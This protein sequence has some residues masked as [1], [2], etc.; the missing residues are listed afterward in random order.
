MQKELTQQQIS[1]MSE[2]VAKY[3]GV[4]VTQAY[5]KTKDQCGLH[6]TFPKEVKLPDSLI[7]RSCSI[8]EIRYHSSW[9]W[10]HEV[11]EKIKLENICTKEFSTHLDEIVQ[12][13]IN[14]TK[15]EAF[16]ALFNVVEF[17]NE[18]KK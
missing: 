15:I 7:Y 16:T 10:I 14:G 9:D 1:S 11:W 13:I 8:I 5:S 17:I 2:V 12:K 18:I 3:M 6:F 4:E